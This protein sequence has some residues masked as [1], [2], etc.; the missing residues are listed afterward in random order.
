MIRK[1]LV[2]LILGLV[3]VGSVWAAAPIPHTINFQGKLT[4]DGVPLSAPDKVVRF[5]IDVDNDGVFEW[6]EQWKTDNNNPPPA[7]KI[8]VDQNGIFSVVL[9]TIN[10]INIDFSSPKAVLGVIY[11]GTNLGVQPI[12]SVPYAYV[13]EFS[14]KAQ[15]ADGLSPGDIVI[16]GNLTV[17]GDLNVEGTT[18]LN[19]TNIEG[20]L[21]VNNGDITINGQPVTPGGGGQLTPPVMLSGEFDTVLS[22]TSTKQPHGTG[23]FG[24]SGGDG[25]DAQ[26]PDAGVYG[27]NLNTGPGVYGYGLKGKGVFGRG[28]L[29]GAI[30]VFGLAS[31]DENNTQIGVEN[32]GVKGSIRNK[33]VGKLGVLTKIQGPSGPKLLKYGVYGK[34]FDNNIPQSYAG[35]FEG[36]RG[37]KIDG[38][39]EVTGDIKYGE[40][41][42]SL[43]DIFGEQG[44][45][46]QYV[47]KSGDTMT[48]ALSIQG[49]AK[50]GY[51]SDS[52]P[53]NG[54]EAI[55]SSTGVLGE[56]NYNGYGIYGVSK[57]LL[58]NNSA[59]GVYGTVAVT[60]VPNMSQAIGV[61]GNVS[62]GTSYGRLGVWGKTN[63]IVYYRGVEGYSKTGVGVYGGSKSS[64]NPA[65]RAINVGNGPGLEVVNASNK[66]TVNID[67]QGSGPALEITSGKNIKMHGEIGDGANGWDVVVNDDL[68]VKDKVYIGGDTDSSGNSPLVQIYRKPA[69]SGEKDGLKVVAAGYGEGIE[70]YAKKGKGIYVKTLAQTNSNPAILVEST[71]PLL[72]K[73]DGRNLAYGT[74]I[75]GVLTSDI[76]TVEMSGEFRV[77]KYGNVYSTGSVYIAGQYYID[78]QNILAS[79]E[80]LQ[81]ENQ[82]LKNKVVALESKLDEFMAAYQRERELASR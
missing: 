77:D 68:K 12:S 75:D 22:A 50:A 52:L 65:I 5:S 28:S 34:S 7:Q 6:K 70:A 45:L 29:P 11:D 43:N 47:K 37:V 69:N 31:S 1:I 51:D 36:G 64:T 4:K 49:G 66:A 53:D 79:V 26:K 60:T 15:T 16:D 3:V 67:N 33:V 63:N 18:N 30:G 57:A 74:A 42:V 62:S 48:G 71:S 21:T 80:K 55:G 19:A 81:A 78:G 9:G 23:L 58:Q 82:Q 32:V 14:Y 56:V 13:S 20:D 24:M 8:Y 25:T 73:L 27:I 35:Y 44:Y 46:N 39:L 59:R 41:G 72:L 54:L 38:D 61:E 76:D 17:T 10:P 40:D 2:G